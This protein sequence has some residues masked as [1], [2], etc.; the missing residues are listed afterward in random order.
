MKKV[1]V[2][3]ARLQSTRLPNKLMLDLKG[4]SIIQR[5]YEQCLLV[6]NIDK[7]IIAVDDE[8]LM[9]HCNKFAK[10]VVLTSSHHQSGTDRIAEAIE[11]VNC[12]I[13]INVQGDEPFIDPHL[14]SEVANCFSNTH[15]QMASAMC[16][17]D[18]YNEIENPNNVKVIVNTNNEAIYFSRLPIPYQRE[19]KEQSIHNYYKH[20]GIYGYQ[21]EFLI[22]FSKMKPTILEQTEKLEQLRVI[23]NGYTIKM[24]KTTHNAIGIDTLED[25]ESAKKIIEQVDN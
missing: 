8:K 23:E 22:Q 13:V 14:I 15:T 19:V 1:I 2:I 18:N 10:D 3:P 12:D 11:K 17:M 5:V 21:K 7:V 9:I 16:R 6:E 25:Y 20:L 4:K 24:I